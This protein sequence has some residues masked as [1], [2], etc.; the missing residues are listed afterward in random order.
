MALMIIVIVGHQLLP[1][2]H[3]EGVL[4]PHA[5]HEGPH[6]K[7]AI[8]GDRKEKTHEKKEDDCD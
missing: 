2:T 7:L 3:V 5:C 4:A 6:S 1:G 8:Q